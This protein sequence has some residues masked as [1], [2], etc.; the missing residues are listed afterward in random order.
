[1]ALGAIAGERFDARSVHSLAVGVTYADVERACDRL[2]ERDLLVRDEPGADRLSL[3]FR[4]TLIRDVA[5]A[6]LAKSARAGL[7]ERYAAWLEEQGSELPEA[8]ARI[9]FHLESA[10]RFAGEVGVGAPHAMTARA[11]RRLAAA[12]EAAHGR[13]DLAGEVGFLDRAVTLLGSGSPEGAELLPFLVSALFESGESDRAEALADHAVSVSGS[14]GLARVH[15]RA[16]IEREHIRLSCHPETFRPELSATV[17]AEAA[18]TLRALGDEH[19]L[20]RAAYLRCDLSWLIGDPMRSYVHAEEMLMLARRAGSDFD[21]ATALVFMAWCLVEGPYPAHEA[22]E[23][24]DSLAREAAVEGERAGELSLIGCRAVLMAM[25]G[26]YDEAR[27]DMDRARAGFADLRLDLMAA[28]L[29]LLVALAESLVGDPA[30]AERAVLDAEA[31]VSGPGDR[32]Y[33]AMVNVDFAH[34]IIAQGRRADAI[35]AVERIDLVP[36]PCDLE[37]RVKRL[38]GRARV[39]VQAGEHARAIEEARAAVATAGPS[40]L[41]LVRADAERTLAEALSAAGQI[42]EAVSA[43]GRALALDEAKQNL[44]AASATRRL[45]A[46][47]GA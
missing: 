43:L 10:C 40:G 19:G 33:Q 13:G 24:C 37:W 3:R 47:F 8:D 4:H 36:A 32:W 20:A 15:A 31:M 17:V 5:Y 34:A 41:I 2:V 23:R 46:S 14:L 39:A 25:I 27:G 22:I 44:V 45:L 38:T 30:A 11:G 12:A 1:M 28:Y 18:Q 21:A 9:G 6:S 16:R 42:D 29:A 35:A 26:R 7:H